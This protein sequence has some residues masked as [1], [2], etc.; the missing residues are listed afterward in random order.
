VVFFPRLDEK[1]KG[2]EK[3]EKILKE[4]KKKQVGLIFETGPSSSRNLPGLALEFPLNAL[5]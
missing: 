2:A 4:E 5:K 3:Y 1:K